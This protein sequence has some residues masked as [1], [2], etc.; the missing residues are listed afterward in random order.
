MYSP[1]FKIPKPLLRQDL[2]K[3]GDH[4]YSYCDYEEI[5]IQ[6]KEHFN[7]IEQ[8]YSERA[9]YYEK[10]YKDPKYL[11][12]NHDDYRDLVEHLLFVQSYPA[13]ER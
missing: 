5:V 9:K 8:I 10:F 7:T 12:L 3:V 13:F 11:I 6:A 4:S 2:S 1:Y